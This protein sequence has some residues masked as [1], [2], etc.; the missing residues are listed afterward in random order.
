MY[1]HIL[2]TNSF[3]CMNG[4]KQLNIAME[5]VQETEGSATAD[6]RLCLQG[7]GRYTVEHGPFC[8]NKALKVR[9]TL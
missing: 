8:G 3:L 1:L 6:W 9:F 4:Q 5:T 7:I 2:I